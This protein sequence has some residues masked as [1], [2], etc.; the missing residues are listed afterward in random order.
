M[1]NDNINRLIKKASG[2]IDNVNYEEITYEGYGPKG[3]AI[4]VVALTD[5]R[6]RAAA[7]IRNA[8]TKGGGNMG[9]SGCVSFMFEEKGLIVL[10]T[11]EKI[12]IE[13]LMLFA[14]ENGAQEFEEFEDYIEITT[15]PED[16][17]FIRDTI[18]NKYKISNQEIG[19]Y[20]QNYT[21]ITDVEDLKK[22]D[23]LMYLLE[24]DD[25]VQS[26]FHN[27]I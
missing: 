9:N 10:E 5:N 2:N 25:D 22:F 4:I 23:K 20:P 27:K 16:F 11:T 24:E 8:F 26:I 18:E 19:L 17:S 6:N 12:N 15:K 1:P 21:E 14:I 7:N 13:E 3:V